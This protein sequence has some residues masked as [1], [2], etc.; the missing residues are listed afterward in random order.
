MFCNENPNLMC[1]TLTRET[2]GMSLAHSETLG[3][4]V[5]NDSESPL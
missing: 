5:G 1:D 2:G 3:R 4:Q